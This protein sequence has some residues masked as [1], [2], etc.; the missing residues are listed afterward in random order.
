M[1]SYQYQNGVYQADNELNNIVARLGGFHLLMSFL[2]AIGFIMDG[3]G[4]KEAWCKVYA[5]NSTE[6]MMSGRNFSRAVRAHLLTQRAL[7]KI[8]ITSIDVSDLDIE[9]I[10]RIYS[11]ASGAGILDIFENSEEIN[12]IIKKFI[13]HLNN[14][15]ENFG[16]TAK[17]W[18]QYIHM[19]FLVE[20]FIRAERTGDFNLHMVTTTDMLPYFHAS[21]HFNYAKSVQL[22][23]QYMQ[24]LHRK[25]NADEYKKFTSEGYFT[26]CR[27]D[28]P[29]AGIWSD[30]TIEHTNVPDEIE[31][32][33]IGRGIT[34]STATLWIKAMPASLNVCGSLD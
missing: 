10:T 19:V 6:H 8:L 27:T 33:M 4:L 12:H 29:F 3:S 26:I 18:L 30:M 13:D 22:Y 31:G 32:E 21:E 7:V 34:D 20:Q 2:A 28:K 14:I 11:D 17:L 9:K 16:K 23:C 25:M 5:E 1:Q 15:Q 24:E